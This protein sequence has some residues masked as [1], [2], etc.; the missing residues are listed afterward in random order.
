MSRLVGSNGIAGIYMSDGRLEHTPIK[1][2]LN[3]MCLWLEG[4][5][6]RKPT[7]HKQKHLIRDSLEK[8]VFG[9]WG[10]GGGSL[11]CPE[12]PAD[13]LT[14]ACLHLSLHANFLWRFY[15]FYSL[16]AS[17]ESQVQ[18]LC[19]SDFLWVRTMRRHRVIKAHTCKPV[20]L[21]YVYAPLTG[22]WFE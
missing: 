6:L 14:R 8:V 21:T 17:F 12:G 7:D 16:N 13:A 5:L 2:L 9:S 19:C 10:L 1:A 11:L 20:W 15:T 22:V 4:L 3:H 18:N